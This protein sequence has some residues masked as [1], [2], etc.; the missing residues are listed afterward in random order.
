MHEGEVTNEHARPGRAVDDEP[1]RAGGGRNGHRQDEDP[2]AP[3]RSTVE[4]GRPRVR[5]GRQGRPHRPGRARRCDEPEG[6]RTCRIAGL[7]VRGVRPS[8][9]VPVAQRRARRAG[10]GHRQ[11]VRPAAPRQGPRPQRDPDIDPRARLQVLRRQRPA[12]ARPEGPGD[13]PQVPRVRRGQADPCRVRR[14]VESVGRRAAP[15]D[16][17]ARAGGRRRVLRRARVRRGRPAP[18][19]AGR[20]GRDQRPRAARRHGQAAPVLDVHP[21]A[22]RPAVRAAPR[23]RRPAEAEAVLLLRRGAPAVRRRVRGAD[24]AD[25]ANRPPDPLEGRRRVL[26]HPGA[27][28]RAVVGAG[29]ARQPGPARAAGVHAGRRRRAAQDRPH[30]PDDRL[31]RRRAD[32]HVARHRRGAGHRALPGLASPRRWPRRGCSRRIR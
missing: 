17:G 21:V 6:G 28:R 25:R 27:D 10:A 22:A 26:R 3:R 4:G 15:L 8:G 29:P 16:R 23:G 24:G 5:P 32:D 2:A 30:V 14:D 9:R 12:A 1:P 31:L 18:H 13:N 11:L 19:G 20:L 7:A